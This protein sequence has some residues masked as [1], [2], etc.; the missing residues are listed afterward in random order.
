MPEMHGDLST[1]RR[2]HSAKR[3]NS[4]IGVVSKV[5]VDG[6]SDD[7]FLQ[8]RIDQHIVFDERA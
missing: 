7:L 4:L 5:S 1:V 3:M 2:L 6:S 8:R